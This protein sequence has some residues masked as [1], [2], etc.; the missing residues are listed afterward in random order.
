MGR[1]PFFRYGPSK[2]DYG[3]FFTLRK[4]AKRAVFRRNSFKINFFTKG[5]HIQL[6]F[7][8]FLAKTPFGYCEFKGASVRKCHSLILPKMACFTR[9]TR[10]ACNAKHTYA[11]TRVV[12]PILLFTPTLVKR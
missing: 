7:V 11:F 4:N 9:F 1:A 3:R 6:D 5:T 2:F 12:Q 10:P 8:Y